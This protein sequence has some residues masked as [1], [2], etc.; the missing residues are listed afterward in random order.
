MV[1]HYLG[2]FSRP[3]L[4]SHTVSALWLSYLNSMSVCL[5]SESIMLLWSLS[6]SLPLSLCLFNIPLTQFWM[7]GTCFSVQQLQMA[8]PKTTVQ[9]GIMMII[10]HN[11]K[12]FLSF[13]TFVVAVH[14]ILI[15][16]HRRCLPNSVYLMCHNVD[17]HWVY[18]M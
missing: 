1:V 14:C 8:F 17:V 3:F 2:I 7:A 12:L 10:T 5:N 18:K 4:F 13:G 11:A 6:V 16:V 9:N 15:T